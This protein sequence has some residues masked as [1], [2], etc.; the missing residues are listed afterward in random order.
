MTTST[1]LEIDNPQPGLRPDEEVAAAWDR[2]AASARQPFSIY[3]SRLWW[4]H[5]QSGLFPAVTSLLVLRN[6]SSA[7]TGVVPLQEVAYDLRFGVTSSLGL[8]VTIRCASILGGEPLAPASP[9]ALGDLIQAVFRRHSRC[10]GILMKS[11][12]V[13]SPMWDALRTLDE[14][15]ALGATLYLPDGVRCFR[16][17]KLPATHREYLAKFAHK[18]RYN[19]E[20]Q[21]R[22]LDRQTG[23]RLRLLTVTRSDQVAEF[24]AMV[25]RTSHSAGH[26]AS[27]EAVCPVVSHVRSP[28]P[29]DRDLCRNALRR[30]RDHAWEDLADRGVFRSYVLAAGETPLAFV[31]GYNYRGI[32]H[33]SDTAFNRNFASFAPGSTLVH[34]VIRDL[35]E[36]S[37]CE[38]VSFGITDAP[39][40]RW[41]SNQSHHDAT[42][43]I[44]RKSLTSSV[45]LGTHVAYKRARRVA[46]TLLRRTGRLSADDRR[47][48]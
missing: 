4:E 25:C 5:L 31:I 47:G 35:I 45:M 23:G 43:L 19:L 40:K 2:L 11:V 10:D 26:A 17:L 36:T 16:M 3:Q 37:S 13:A 28:G 22:L 8:R 24:A 21:H 12:R 20:R 15:R 14:S 41:F 39:Y 44:L 29:Y 30:S 1:F 42:V 9:A 46:K 32:Y 27:T 34:L 33:Y 7:P 38:F 48:G 6:G 18:K